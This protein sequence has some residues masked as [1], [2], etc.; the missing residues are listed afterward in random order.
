MAEPSNE[1][2]IGSEGS[3]EQAKQSKFAYKAMLD[4]DA[5]NFNTIEKSK[6]RLQ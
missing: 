6:R 4:E 5:K 1:F 2:F 3:P